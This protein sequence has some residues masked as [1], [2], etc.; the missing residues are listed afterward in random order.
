MTS[1]NVNK[2][3]MQQMQPT[4]PRNSNLRELPIAPPHVLELSSRCPSTPSAHVKPIVNTSP[5][6]R[7]GLGPRNAQGK[8]EVQV[9]P[10]SPVVQPKEEAKAEAEV[11]VLSELGLA[12]SGRLGHHLCLSVPSDPAR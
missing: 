11:G 10:V 3:P 6:T 7:P 1:Q 8:A 12:C 9:K 2:R 4:A 5:P